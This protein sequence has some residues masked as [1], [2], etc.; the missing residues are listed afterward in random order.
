LRRL[1]ALADLQNSQESLL[2]NLRQM[3]AADKR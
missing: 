1:N 3:V 2:A